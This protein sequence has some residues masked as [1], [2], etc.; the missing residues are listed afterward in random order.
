MLAVAS[1]QCYCGPPAV[2]SAGLHE[3]TCC[4]GIAA[5]HAQALRQTAAEWFLHPTSAYI[6]CLADLLFPSGMAWA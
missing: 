2:A 6:T 3:S 5:Q 1:A 4:S